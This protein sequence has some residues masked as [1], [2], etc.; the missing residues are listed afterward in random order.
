MAHPKLKKLNNPHPAYH[1]ATILHGDLHEPFYSILHDVFSIDFMQAHVSMMWS[2]I[3]LLTII[4]KLQ[5][6]PQTVWRETGEKNFWR[7]QKHNTQLRTVLFR[8]ELITQKKY[9]FRRESHGFCSTRRSLGSVTERE[10]ERRGED[11][12]IF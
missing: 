4:L 8:V 6:T 1:S 2:A 3:P 11:T 5:P 9:Q 12:G 10:R 7:A